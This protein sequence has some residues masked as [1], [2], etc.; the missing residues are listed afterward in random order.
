VTGRPVHDGG[1]TMPAVRLH[2]PG[3]RPTLDE[4]PVPLP[5]SGEVRVRVR[6]C[7][8]CG[9]DVHLVHG[10]TPTGPLPLTLGH[11]PSGV[12]DDPGDSA[13][14]V[15]DRVSVAAGY[16]CGECAACK[17]DRENV[18]PR[19]VIPGIDRDGAQATYVVVPARALVPLPDS[20]DFATGAILTDAVATPFHAIR[21]SGIEAGQTAVV[22]GLG[23]L[24]LHAVTILKQ[25]VGARVIGVDVLPAAR[26]R[27]LAFGADEVVDGSDKPA[28]RVREMTGGGADCAYEFVGA[29]AVTDQAVKSLARGGT[30]TVVGVTPERLALGLPQAL[31]VAGELRIQGSFGCSRAELVELVGLVADGRLDLAGTIT[32]RFPLEQFDDA[33][34][35]L[36]TKEGD[37]IRVVVE[38]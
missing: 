17:A 21:R 1:A 3:K 31:L 29:A 35:V 22:Y 23:G 11:E 33:L 7:G 4:V 27:A 25:V 34:R 12:I 37:P 14:H 24:G 9:S 15:G 13:W 36:E 16:G 5:G 20:V 8:I 30:C 38:Q 28:Q 32:H 18:C 19:L 2:A 6:A 26:E 10:V